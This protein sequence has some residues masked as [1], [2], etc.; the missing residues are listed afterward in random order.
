MN[1]RI[2]ERTGADLLDDVLQVA[3]RWLDSAVVENDVD[4]WFAKL[5]PAAHLVNT[6]DATPQRNLEAPPE[7]TAARPSASGRLLTELRLSSFKSVGEAI[8]VPLKPLTLIYG[9]NS[10]GKSSLIQSVLFMKQSVEAGRVTSNGPYASLGSV[11]G[12]AH[13]HGD[14]PISVGISFASSPDIDSMA[15]LPNPRESRSV[16]F[17]F[18]PDARQ[19]QPSTVEIGLGEQRFIWH[20]NETNPQHVDIDLEQ[21]MSMTELSYSQSS[22]FPPRRKSTSNQPGA[23]KRE[24]R[25]MDMASAEFVLEHLTPRAPT[26]ELLAEVKHRM[27]GG[28]RTGRIEGILRTVGALFGAVGDELSGI[29]GKI[30]YLGPLRRAPE[31]ISVR[32]PEAERLDVPFFLLD[33]TSE[34]EEVSSKLRQLGVPYELDVVTVSN[35]ADQSLFGDMAALVLTD[36]RT[37]VRLSPA[38]VGFGISQVLPIVTELSARTNSVILIEQPEIHLHPAMQAD[39]ADI[40]I[41][42]IDEAGRANQVIAETHSENIMLR[43]QRRVR[44]GT[45]SADDVAVLYVDQDDAGDAYVRRLRLDKEGDFLDSWPHGFFAERFDE[46]FG[47]LS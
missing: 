37:G 5:F 34:R 29:V 21:L 39:L 47:E 20:R 23:V 17:A 31:R 8:T 19:T 25:R 33:N 11:A 9:R 18:A 24:F 22:V 30:A 26:A 1:A 40:L 28:T 4:D 41:D 7:R 35:P 16:A 12:V 46:V 10:A 44:E 42:S 45:L 3:Q 38:D 15:V 2:S 43:V 6:N 27:S 14:G 32:S 13:N 36:T